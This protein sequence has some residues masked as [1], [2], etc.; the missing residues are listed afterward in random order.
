[1]LASHPAIVSTYELDFFSRFAGS[2]YEQWND[3][4]RPPAGWHKPA[5]H[6]LP[7]AMTQ[8]EFELAIGRVVESIYTALLAA[9]PS[10]TL[11]LEKDPNYSLC[12]PNILRTVP[13]GRFIH[14]IRD[15]RDVVHSMMRVA[16]TW[17]RVWA[18]SSVADA[19]LR[20]KRCV[21]GA[22]TARC[23]SGY[24]EVLY[25][26]LVGDGGGDV[27]GEMF[28]FCR[29]KASDELVTTLYDLYQYRGDQDQVM[30]GGIVVTGE[31]RNALD[32]AASHE[33]DFIVDP[34]PGAWRRAFSPRDRREF[35]EVAGD[36]LIELGY[37]PNTEWLDGRE[38]EA[39]R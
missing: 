5:F 39:R 7:S 31:G 30:R 34:A 2:W 28:A 13:H 3:H 6:G 16:Q 25:E 15:G 38:L 33:K 12:V 21:V 8:R 14:L 17:A 9:K 4:C 27:L 10:A 36:L 37:E 1:M 26:D 32:E 22:R 23:A 29:V 24:L 19:A 11:V 35:H 18:P 20:W